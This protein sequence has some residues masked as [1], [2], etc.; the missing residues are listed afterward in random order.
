MKSI[1]IWNNKASEQQLEQLSHRLKEGEIAIIPTDTM[2]AIVGDALNIKVVDRICKLKNINP[3]KTNLSI[4]CCDISM[5]AEYSRIDDK[6]FRLLKE[7]CPGPFTFLFKSASTLPRAF[8]GRKT[9]GVRIPD[10]QF[11]VELV[12][13]MGNPLITTSIEYEDEDY[14]INPE[15]IS[16]A[17][18]GRVDIMVEGDSGTTEV[19]TIVDCTLDEPEII[20]EGLGKMD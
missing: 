10:N 6:G 14:A 5:A 11:D 20:R 2:Y 9:V 4:I 1:K 7:Y 13:R 8:K 16:E 12:E 17:Y 15:L 19:S 3:D 18:E